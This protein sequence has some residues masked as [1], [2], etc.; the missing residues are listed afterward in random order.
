MSGRMS[1]VA[2]KQMEALGWK[3]VEGIPLTFEA[4][5]PAAGK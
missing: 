2:R 5:K 3:V 1:E 4:A